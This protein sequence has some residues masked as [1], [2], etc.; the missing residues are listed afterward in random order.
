MIKIYKPKA[1]DLDS[2]LRNKDHVRRRCL[3]VASER[4]VIHEHR[5]IDPNFQPDKKI[6]EKYR[7]HEPVY[8][9][10][11]VVD[12]ECF[13]RFGVF[14]STVVVTNVRSKSFRIDVVQSIRRF[15]P[16][17]GKISDR[18]IVKAERSK[19]IN[20][21]AARY[22][23]KTDTIGNPDWLELLDHDGKVYPIQNF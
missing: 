13:L 8:D 19:L 2:I 6:A 11:A 15:K 4:S 23:P 1:A 22:N 14:P 5:I 17:P 18:D 9:I 20:F 16:I 3:T 7:I 21:M 12:A 10:L